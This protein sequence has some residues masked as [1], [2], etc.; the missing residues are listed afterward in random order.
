MSIAEIT[1]NEIQ[2]TYDEICIDE[3]I[4]DAQEYIL[5]IILELQRILKD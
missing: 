1:L 2:S 5:Q 3:S 4:T